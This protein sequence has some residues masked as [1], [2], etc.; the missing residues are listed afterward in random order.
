VAFV[1]WPWGALLLWP[2]IALL[3][4][5]IGYFRLG[6]SIYRKSEGVLPISTHFTLGPCLVGQH[7]SL[8]YYRHQCRAWDQVMPQVLVGRILSGSEASAAMGAGVKTVLDLAAE[9]SETKPFREIYYRN[10]PILDLTAP[11][12]P[13]LSEMANF[14][15]EHSQRGVVYVHCKIG[16]SRSAAAV[17]AWLLTITR[18]LWRD[19]Q[20]R[21][22][23][24]AASCRFFECARS[25]FR[26]A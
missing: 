26:R 2:G 23:R 20:R 5:A 8:Q 14:I 1:C 3:V 21:A 22:W 25:Q 24:S 6:P 18:N 13:Q 16:Y 10:I 17:V 12:I 7:L 4:A 15:E 11:T 9:F 19:R